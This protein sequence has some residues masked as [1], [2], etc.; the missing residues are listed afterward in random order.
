MDLEV[1]LGWH[2]FAYLC[3]LLGCCGDV[4]EDNMGSGNSHNDDD[5]PKGNGALDIHL[6]LLVMAYLHACEVLVG[7]TPKE[8]DWVVHRVK[9]FQ[10][11]GNSLL[12]VWKNGRV[13]VVPCPK[14]HEG[15]AR[16]VHEKLGHFGVRWMFALS[17]VLVAWDVIT[18]LT[19]H[20]SVCGV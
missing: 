8:W 16:H 10:C 20:F 18:S 2:A 11:E 13:C 7:L 12:R 17:T 1:V 5:K 3:T 15:L 14:Q 19:I 4:C 9:W 6:D